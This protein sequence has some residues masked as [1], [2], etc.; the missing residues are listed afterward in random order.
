M[1]LFR[2]VLWLIIC[3]GLLFTVQPDDTITQSFIVRADEYRTTYAY[4]PAAEYLRVAAVRQPW[5]ASLYLRLG[6]IA[7]DQHHFDEA[8]SQLALAGQY[9]ADAAASAAVRAELA[10]QQNRFDEAAGQWQVVINTQPYNQVAAQSLIRADTHARNWD[11]ARSAAEAWLARLPDSPQAQGILAELLAVDDPA[12]AQDHLAYAP[13][14][15]ARLYR[16]ALNEADPALRSELLGRAY[17]SQANLALAARA[18]AD[19]IAENPAYA[20]AY[21]YSGFTLDQLGEDG[22]PSFDQ[23]L[24]L[25]PNLI[26]ARYFRARHEWMHGDPDS[27]L[28]D[29]KAALDREPANRLITA[30]L[31]R[32]YLQRS[33][34]ASAEKW[35]T[36]ARDLD[37]T[38]PIG[39][40]TLAELY[41]G[42]AYG[43]PAQAVSTAQQAVNLAPNDAAAHLWLGRA[44]LISGDRAQAEGELRRLIELDP[45]SA[46]AHL[47]L[48]RF[49]SKSNEEGRLEFER[50]IGLD[51]D[52]PIGMQASR[53]LEMP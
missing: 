13:A 39:W 19:A 46:T 5:N 28:A 26:A 25:D 30:E 15:A 50:A 2:L 18:F 24:V 23:A 36:A 40:K 44:Y 12:G 8:Q 35:L 9:G 41:I 20:E 10:E 33:E 6:S 11:A 37:P 45:R 17:L 42:R 49:L 1:T 27:A 3:V 48:G 47:Y 31:G 29:L 38:D 16:P 32:V 51:P 43:S 21:A 22:K 7:V 14:E 52:G 4:A 34:Y 53:E